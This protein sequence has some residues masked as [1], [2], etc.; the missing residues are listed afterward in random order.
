M[1]AKLYI[2]NESHYKDFIVLNELWITAHFTIEAGDIALAENPG[3]V[4]QKG[5]FILS[6]LKDD[7]VVGVCALFNQ[8]NG[9]YE[10]A[11]LAVDERHRKK[12]HGDRLIKEAL[13]VLKS[14]GIKKVNLMSNTKLNAA[15]SLY[16]KNG[17]EMVSE[18]IHPVY[19]RCN[20][21]MERSV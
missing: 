21:V 19:S 18:G 16:K 20:I 7:T 15:I 8:G 9:C 4:V 11:R 10:L 2:N 14:N 17:F 6:L 3:S 12:G 1:T 13:D 5:G